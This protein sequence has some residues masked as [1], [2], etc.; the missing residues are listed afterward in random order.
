M[1]SLRLLFVG[2]VVGERGC[3][4]VQ[5]LVPGLRREL[6]LDA[7][8]VNGENS[9]GGL[10]ITADTGEALLSAA[11]FLTLGDHT[12]DREGAG[13]YL[14]RE[15][16]VVRPANL[17]VGLPG[18]GWGMFEAAGKRIGVTNVQGR[19][20]MR[21]PH[22]PF[23]AANRAVA[24]LEAAGA[25]LILVDVHA[26][27]TSEKQAMGWYLSGR[28]AAVLGTH[29]HV[30]TNDLRVLPGGTAYATDVGMTGAED[31][32]IGF[33]REQ[34][35]RLFLE[36]GPFPDTVAEGAI[37]LNAVLVQVEGRRAV[38]VEQISRQLSE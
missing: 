22:S 28:V 15:P 21:T 14:D 25:E 20:F 11:D 4:A 9:A 30:P 34:W 1:A 16:R 17:E 3:A 10:G 12:F 7:V 23:E 35:L 2:D 8:I 27:A 31:G 37:R 18:R 29:T 5:A 32:I 13:E 36:D 19:V 26:E 38:A 6:E 33:N 24:V